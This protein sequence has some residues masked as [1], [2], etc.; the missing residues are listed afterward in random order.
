MVNGKVDQNHLNALYLVAAVATVFMTMII[1]IQPLFLKSIL[2]LSR[3]NAGF[4]N[5]N[6]QV[7]TEIADLLFIGYF[8]YLSDRFG[9]ISLIVSGF[10][11]A[12]VTTMIA[13]FCGLIGAFMGLSGLAVFYLARIIIS[14][15]TAAVWPQI[16]TLTGDFS[17]KQ[18]RPGLLARAGFMMGLGATLSYAALMRIPQNAGVTV[19]MFFLAIIAFAG[20]WLAKNLLVD[21]IPRMEAQSMPFAELKTLLYKQRKLRLTFLA[22]FSSRNDMVMIGLFLMIWFIYFADLLALD[23]AEAAA[24]GGLII[25]Y[26]GVVSL[27]SIPAWGSAI[28]RYGRVH[29]IAMGMGLTGMGLVSF[30]FIINPFSLWILIPSTLVAMGQ[31]GCLLAPQTLTLD[32]APERIR[33]SV[34]GAFNT[35]G[36]LGIVLFLFAGGILFDKAGPPAPFVFTGVANLLIMFY[37]LYI[38]SQERACEEDEEGD[39]KPEKSAKPLNIKDKLAI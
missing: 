26:I 35:V 31:A 6:I 24:R 33:G 28:E 29:S 17:N 10:A 38:L 13:P 30:G 9:R 20:A 3:E 27:I 4:I 34:L 18:T 7:A 37:A 19:S 25:G 22:A 11:L 39:I 1:A 15:G 12:G 14:L 36:C 8:G 16:V 23:H 21:I 5:S 2:G 32:L